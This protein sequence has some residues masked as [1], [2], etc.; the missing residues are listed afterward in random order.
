MNQ[1]KISQHFDAMFA[2]CVRQFAFNPRRITA[3][4]R[5]VGTEGHGK[6]MVYI[7][8]TGRHSQIALKGTYVTLREQHGEKP[9]WTD[10]ERAW[11]KSTDAEIDAEI[12][13]KQA[14]LEYTRNSRLYQEHRELLLSY[15]SDWPGYQ[16]GRPNPRA[17][18]KA[19]IEDLSNAHDER[20]SPF[21]E[22][23]GTDGPEHLVHLL[24]ASCHLEIE[25]SKG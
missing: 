19:L 13:A 11:Y 9:H 4:I 12:A 1:A 20:L 17:A 2:A 8:R 6:D 14:E 16:A 5:Y 21:S 23:I 18:A 15:H 7:F 25:A 3:G 10:V 24:L 22:H